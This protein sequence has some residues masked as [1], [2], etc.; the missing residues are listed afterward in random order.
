MQLFKH[1]EDTGHAVPLAQQ[2]VKNGKKDQQAKKKAK[3]KREGRGFGG[4]VR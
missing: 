1:L 3:P 2:P 4:A